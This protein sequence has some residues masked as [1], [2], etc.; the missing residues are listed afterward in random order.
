[1]QILGPSQ[2]KNYLK[3]IRAPGGPMEV[4]VTTFGPQKNPWKNE[5]IWGPQNMGHNP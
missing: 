1:M 4:I 2:K 3:M 5:G